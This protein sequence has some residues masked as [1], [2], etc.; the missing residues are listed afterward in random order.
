MNAISRRDLLIG[1]LAVGAAGLAGCSSSGGA[2]RGPARSAAELFGGGGATADGMDSTYGFIIPPE[3]L[4]RWQSSRR[5]LRNIVLLGDSIVHGYVGGVPGFATWFRSQLEN[6]FGADQVHAGFYG[7]WRGMPALGGPLEWKFTDAW[8]NVGLGPMNWSPHGLSTTVRAA[9]GGR[10][11]VATFTMPAGVVCHEFDVVLVAAKGGGPRGLSYSV[12]GGATWMGLPVESPAEPKIVRL[13]VGA[14]ATSPE[15]IQLRAADAS[16]RPSAIAALLGIDVRQGSEGWVLHNMG[17]VGT[18]LSEKANLKGE[19]NASLHS[20]GN[21]H[22]LLDA[23]APELIVSLWSNDAADDHFDKSI[24]SGA[25]TTYAKQIAPY[26]DLVFLGSPMQT[27]K[28]IV[29]RSA[30][31]QRA[32]AEL[33]TEQAITGGH[34]MVDYRLRWGTTAVNV[35]AGL[36][37]D[38]GLHPAKRGAQDISADLGRLLRLS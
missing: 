20:K 13:T 7:V 10:G 26:A 38:D 23:I 3:G 14:L 18:A 21:W 28:G 36:L 2:S 30:A 4:T 25:V 12:D 16:G 29:G 9:P 17:C 37:Q 8:K 19:S 27:E 11:N 34:A 6:Q 32:V 1:G 15:T 24:M 31:N 22:G 33:W 35:S 5:P